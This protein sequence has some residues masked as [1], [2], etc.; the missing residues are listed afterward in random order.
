MKRMADIA[1]LDDWSKVY[2][3]SDLLEE[4][5]Q[6]GTVEVLTDCAGDLDAQRRRLE[7]YDIIIPIRERTRFTAALLSRLPRLKLIAQTGSGVAHIDVEYA[8]K[9][10]IVI[11]TTPVGS[12][13]SVAEHILGMVLSLA[14]RLNEGDRAVRG[15][16]WPLLV[17]QE[18]RD[19]A[20]GLLGFG[21]IAREVAPR[22][23]A[24]DMKVLAWSPS[25]TLERALAAGVEYCEFDDLFR[26]SD[27][28]SV[29][30]RL[31]EQTR[32]LIGRRELFLLP[33]GAYLI[34]TARGPVVDEEALCDA[35]ENG[36]LAGAGLDVFER[37]PLPNSNRLRG[38]QHV[39]LT[40][41]IG[42]TTKETY[43]NYLRTSI[44]NIRAYFKGGPM[45]V[46]NRTE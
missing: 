16:N 30:V 33:R 46:V 24:L 35:L 34:N 4:L 31:S 40:P 11:A 23:K 32:G 26:R 42:Y 22:A 14:H 39:L 45:N 25:L 13:V 5:R 21:K 9:R 38:H 20:L 18:V 27:F 7:P 36:H 19:R 41:H 12:E 8:T 44:E 15:G 6:F 1:V 17:G 43:E 2:V 3:D 37:E 29:G 28:L 10:G